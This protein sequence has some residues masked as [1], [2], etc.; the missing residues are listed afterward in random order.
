MMAYT[1]IG[2]T[3]GICPETWHVAT[4]AEWNILIAFVNGDGNAL[5]AIG[6]GTGAGEGTNTSGF[7]A[8]LSGV[9]NPS[10]PRFTG[11]TNI[12]TFW[13]STEQISGWVYRT[14]L[15]ATSGVMSGGVSQIT[16]GNP[17]RCI[18]DVQ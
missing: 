6:Q 4:I 9:R 3:R 15:N 18:K 17:V 1:Y 14:N 10:E 13:S 7:S 5:K 11:I 16:Y 2:G 8:M 12:T